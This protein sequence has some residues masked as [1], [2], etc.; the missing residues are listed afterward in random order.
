ME[1]VETGYM[2][3]TNE[4]IENPTEPSILL[5]GINLPLMFN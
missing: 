4:K 1:I 2:V 5:L 3:A